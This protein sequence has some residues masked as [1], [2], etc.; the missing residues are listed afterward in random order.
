MTGLGTHSTK[1]DYTKPFRMFINCIDIIK[2]D[3]III[4]MPEYKGNLQQK[5]TNL[6]EVVNHL[7]C[8]LSYIATLGPNPHDYN[9]LLI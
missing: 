3:P 2:G 1:L 8:K 6:K 5:Q 4:P 9:Q 7:H